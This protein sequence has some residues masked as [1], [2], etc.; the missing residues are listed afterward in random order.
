MF[1]VPHNPGGQTFE[2]TRTDRPGCHLV[3]PPLILRCRGL[4]WTP[5]RC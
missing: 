5:Q 3:R 2:N 4:D 1:A